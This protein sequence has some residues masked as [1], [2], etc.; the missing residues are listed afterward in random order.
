MQVTLQCYPYYPK[1][2]FTQVASITAGIGNLKCQLQFPTLLLFV[3][4]VVTLVPCKSETDADFC[5]AFF[6]FLRANLAPDPATPP[7]NSPQLEPLGGTG[8]P[9]QFALY[10]SMLPPA[11]SLDPSRTSSTRHGSAPSTRA[12]SEVDA[13][14]GLPH[15]GISAISSPI[16]KAAALHLIAKSINEDRASA[17]GRLCRHPLSLF[18][19]S[20]VLLVAF[21]VTLNRD[22]G[23]M[24]VVA[25]GILVFYLS[26]AHYLTMG[27]ETV[28]AA[29][30]PSF[31]LRSST[32]GEEDVVLG[33]TW[34][35]TLIGA[36]VLRLEPTVAASS[37]GSN[38]PT[39]TRRHKS[40]G[41][42]GHIRSLQKR[43]GRG[44]IR[45]WTI[46]QKYRSQG[47]GRDLLREA[48]RTVREKWGK[49]AE[50]GF[51][52]K[53]ANATRVVPDWLDGEPKRRET[54]AGLALRGVAK[55]WEG[56]CRRR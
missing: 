47:V 29:I 21:K 18:M 8:L 30:T 11:P 28:A 23:T 4:E 16:T 3:C 41:S 53:H 45:A 48:V 10:P 51:A 15:L 25:S 34:G 44:V 32:T 46:G 38:S 49:D 33:A 36:L 56:R 54:R 7:V 39:S 12:P 22:V 17:T 14:A 37:T 43:G 6:T 19:L 5:A 13:P 24:L 50:V 42:A 9:P 35:T 20:V 40:R 2:H 26:L 55:E 31:L 52:K 27:L 1:P